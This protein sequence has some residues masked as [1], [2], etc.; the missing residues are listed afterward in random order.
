MKTKTRLLPLLLGCALAAAPLAAQTYR[1]F[2]VGEMDRTLLYDARGDLIKSI[3]GAGFTSVQRLDFGASVVATDGIGSVFYDLDG[4]QLG[5]ARKTSSSWQSVAVSGALAIVT[6][7][8]RVRIF[9]TDG[10][11]RGRDIPRSGAS[12]QSVLAGSGRVVVV[13]D[14]Q[15]RAFDDLGAM[16]FQIGNRSTTRQEVAKGKDR[17]AVVDSRGAQILDRN[18]QLVFVIQNRDAGKLE[19]DVGKDRIVAIDDR[20]VRIYDR[21]GTLKRHIGTRGRPTVTRTKDRIIV[22]DDQDTTVYDK[23]GNPL[24]NPVNKRINTKRHTVIVHDDR[25]II[26]GDNEVVIIDGNGK[27]KK[28]IPTS[29]RGDVTT[30][31]NRVIISDDQDTGIYDKDG[32]PIGRINKTGTK[33]QKVKVTDDRI[34][35]IDENGVRIFNHDRVPQGNTIQTQRSYHSFVQPFAPGLAIR[36]MSASRLRFFDWSGTRVGPTLT[37]T[38]FFGDLSHSGNLLAVP[39]HRSLQLYDNNFAAVGGPVT[40][41]GNPISVPLCFPLLT[42]HPDVVDVARGGQQTYRI[43]A[44]NDHAGKTYMI[45]G[46]MSGFTPGLAVGGLLIPLN[47]DGYLQFTASAPNTLIQ[48]SLGALDGYGR[49]EAAFT[50]PPQIGALASWLSMSSRMTDRSA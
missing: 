30:G 6:D 34:I 33:R 12:R 40:T 18:G 41:K 44:G 28:G 7:G 9:G 22:T 19:V 2:A 8:D 39:Q 4:E 14:N 26:V 38:T 23:D 29:G 16:V 43:D 49:A 47:L 48:R 17:I 25:I 20:G 45:L 50:L 15:M 31:K 36:D 10:K 24:G 42:A 11:Q 37:A 32:K 46:S 5:R 3:P 35:I 27:V 21:T 13:D 1:G